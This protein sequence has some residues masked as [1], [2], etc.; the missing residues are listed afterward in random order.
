MKHVIYDNSYDVAT[1]IKGHS[2]QSIPPEHQQIL[3]H[4][5]RVAQ[6]AGATSAEAMLGSS[7]ELGVQVRLGKTEELERSATERLGV[8]IFIGQRQAIASGNDT[9]ADAI[10]RMV[11]EAFAMAKASPENPYA[12]LAEEK[13][14]ATQFRN[15]HLEDADSLPA[16]QLLERARQTEEAGRSQS[17]ITN[18]EG[19]S[20][21]FTR[22]QVALA[23]SKGFF[24]GYASTTHQLSLSL[25]AGEKD[26]MQRDYAY[27][28][29]R[30]LEAIKTPQEIGLEAAERTLRRLGARKMQTARLP[31]MFDPRVGRQLLGYF[32]SSIN[33]S[34]IARGT[35]FLKDCM[36]QQVFARNIQI[37]DDPHREAGLASRPFDGEGIAGAERALITDGVL[38]SWLLDIATGAQLGLPS[39]GHASR[40]IGGLPSPSASNACILPGDNSPESLMADMRDGL[41]VTETFGMGVNLVTGD[42]SQGATGF[43]VEGGQK[44]YPVQE[45]TIAGNLRD[46]FH[47]LEAANDLRV[48][49]SINTPTLRVESL[50]VAGN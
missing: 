35:S 5:L 34:A 29:A 8:R 27:S 40:G 18:S 16:E 22:R 30:H 19:A 31:V 38:Q 4:T 33:G 48:E 23:T 37:V 46:I 10:D 39:T 1:S 45:I 25:I 12:R 49:S 9:S 47:T 15:L 14:Y 44:A 50:M 21:S 28:M 43:W 2:M 20:A 3:E 42:Y 26:A 13:E 11:Q 7:T 17:G 41:Y 36:Q 32:L 6:Q 24:G